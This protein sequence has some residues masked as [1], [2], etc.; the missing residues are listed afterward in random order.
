MI[1]YSGKQPNFYCKRYSLNVRSS[2]NFAVANSLSLRLSN[3][4][5][6]DKTYYNTKM[7]VKQIL[8]K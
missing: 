1:L 8:L 4:G 6:I 5:R 7:L 3:S 2:K